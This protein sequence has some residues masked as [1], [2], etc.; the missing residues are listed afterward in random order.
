MTTEKETIFYTVAEVAQKLRV[1]PQTVRSYIRTGRLK[2]TR[3]GRPHLISSA[4]LGEFS[5]KALEGATSVNFTL[6]K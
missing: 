3:V 2:S 5:E 4:A 6:Q 1:T